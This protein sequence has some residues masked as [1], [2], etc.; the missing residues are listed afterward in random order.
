M[1]LWRNPEWRKEAA[2]LAGLGILLSL[3]ALLVKPS[4][5]I[6]VLAVTAVMNLSYFFLTWKRYGDIRTM[7]LEIDKIL[8]GEDCLE[9]GRYREGD[10]AILRDEIYKM[11]I[12]LREQ[13]DR[14]REDKRYL[15]DTLADISHQIRT[16]LTALNLTASRLQ[17][18]GLEETKKGEL[19]METKR[20]LTQVEWLVESLLKMSKLDAGSISFAREQIQMKPFLDQALQTLAIPMELKNQRVALTVAEECGFEGD[21]LWTMEAVMNVLK[22]CVEYTPVNGTITIT[23]QENPLYTEL[24][25]QD[26]GAGISKDDM[27]HLFE[28]FY[29][30]RQSDKNSFGIGLALSRSI[31]K[32]EDAVIKA[33][34]L[35]QGGSRFV[36]RFYLGKRED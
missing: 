16:P 20:L 33:E 32:K 5:V 3:S 14:L 24:A 7:S 22:N 31:L 28:R 35:P 36:I 8:H 29:R 6:L 27:P 21:K 9:L 25:I 4:A 15:A 11:T 13:A 30:G 23:A 18:P 2:G 34:N 10:L 19:L 17:Q 26:S 1:N 12:R